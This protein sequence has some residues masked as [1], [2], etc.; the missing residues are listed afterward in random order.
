MYK[1]FVDIHSH[2]LPG[3]DDGAADMDES[4]QILRKMCE[5][6]VSDLFLTP[7]YCKRRGYAK[8]LGD[9]LGVYYDLKRKCQE[10]NLP[11][12]LHIGTEMEY[13]QDGP[14]YIK[15]GRVAALSDSNY[16]LI[17]FAP[18]VSSDFMLHAVKEIIGYGFVPVIA[19]IERYGCVH[20]NFDLIYDLKEHGALLQVNIRSVSQCSFMQ[21]RFMKAL[22]SRRIADFLAGDVHTEPIEVQEMTKCCNFVI[23]NSD[24]DYLNDLLYAN[25]KKYLLSKEKK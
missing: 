5:I 16:I 4:I 13:S 20:S 8:A 17:E 19:H 10:E 14:R 7:H 18:Y 9:V 1:E 3:I 24:T 11:V 22:F 12:K 23:K 6:G 25:A 2:I 21:R 15:E